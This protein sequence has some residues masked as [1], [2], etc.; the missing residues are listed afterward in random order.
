MDY[1]FWKEYFESNQGHFKDI[2]WEGPDGLTDNEAEFIYKSIR[3]FQHGENSE[4]RHL[5]QFAKK[6]NNEAYL[7]CIRF[8]IKEEQMHAAVLGKFMARYRIRKIKSHW[9]DIVFRR[10]RKL[11]GLE[12]SILVLLTAEIISK[13]YYEALGNVTRSALLQKICTQI[14]RDEDQHIAFQCYTLGLLHSR[15]NLLSGFLTRSWHLV[16][17]TGTLLIVWLYHGKVLRKGGF[18][19]SRFFLQTML[20]FLNTDER[21][22]GKSLFNRHP[23]LP[24]PR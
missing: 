21:I 16:L 12:N 1:S 6:L 5:F 18:Y 11:A 3:Q 22:K 17:M 7:Q 9:I 10:L 24:A 23:F 19:F 20:L 4:G 8:F 14:L 2:D 15:K 13:I